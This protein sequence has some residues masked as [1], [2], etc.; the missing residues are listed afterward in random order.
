MSRC[1]DSRPESIVDP[2]FVGKQ[3]LR[4]EDY[5]GYGLVSNS[6]RL[7]FIPGR[8]QLP[9]WKHQSNYYIRASLKNSFRR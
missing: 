8:G 3:E 5:V 7:P 1:I 6:P 4:D 9:R 2:T